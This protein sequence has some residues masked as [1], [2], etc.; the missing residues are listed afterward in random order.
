MTEVDDEYWTNPDPALAFK[1]PPGK[2]SKIAFATGQPL[3]FVASLGAG[4]TDRAIDAAARAFPAWRALLPQ[5]RAAMREAL[6]RCPG[7]VLPTSEESAVPAP[8]R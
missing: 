8:E 2:P 1:Q 3:A 5:E 7:Q 6:T 4:D